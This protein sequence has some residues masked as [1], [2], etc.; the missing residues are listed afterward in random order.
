MEPVVST[1][2][3]VFF[4]IPF[5]NLLPVLVRSF[6]ICFIFEFRIWILVGISFSTK[7]TIEPQN[8]RY[9]QCKLW[10]VR[11]ACLL[12]LHLS[13]YLG[14]LLKLSLL[15]WLTLISL[16]FSTFNVV[17][18]RF[19]VGISYNFNCFHCTLFDFVEVCNRNNS[20]W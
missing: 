9:N 1:A 20:F 4:F 16:H 18:R 2:L 12:S 10:A 5:W 13:D 17:F 7:I 15:L 3:F 11:R 14:E 6:S 8:F 19:W